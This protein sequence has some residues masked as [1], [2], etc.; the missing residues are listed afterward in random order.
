MPLEECT[1]LPGA[2]QGQWRVGRRWG[3]MRP[4]REMLRRP[5]VGCV[6]IY[7]GVSTIIEFITQRGYVQCSRNDVCAR[8]EHC[9]ER[10]TWGCASDGIRA[11]GW[12]DHCWCM[13]RAHSVH[14]D[15]DLK[16]ML[17]ISLHMHFFQPRH[18]YGTKEI[19][20]ALP[21]PTRL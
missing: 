1:R 20:R 17:V 21:S 2:G 4:S 9:H 18:I 16:K 10:A 19:D 6:G 15:S 13:G 7:E 5:G 8:K 3:M 12:Y 14:S 11:S